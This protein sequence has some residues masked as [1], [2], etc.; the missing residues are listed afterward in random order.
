[1]LWTPRYLKTQRWR[2]EER[3]REKTVEARVGDRERD[4]DGEEE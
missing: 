3:E 2:R 4:R 1:M